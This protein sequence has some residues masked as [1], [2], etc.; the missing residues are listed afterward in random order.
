MPDSHIDRD[1]LRSRRLPEMILST[2]LT[3]SMTGPSPPAPYHL[4]TEGRALYRFAVEGNAIS[5]FDIVQ[6]TAGGNSLLHFICLKG[7]Y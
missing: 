3:S 1:A 4:N 2:G 5:T 7:T 6:S